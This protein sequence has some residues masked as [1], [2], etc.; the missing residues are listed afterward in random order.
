MTKTAPV[1]L[2]SLDARASSDIPFEFEYILPNGEG[3]GIFLSILGS[4]SKTVTEAVNKMMNERRRI[5][6]T[7]ELNARTGGR[8][9]AAII[10]VEDDIAFGQKMAAIRLVGWKGIAEPFDPDLALELCEMNQDIANQINERSN[11]L[12]NF[13]KGSSPA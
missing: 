1:S 7:A 11:D 6:E 13:M 5:A 10:P 2:K 3:S 4:Q 9:T 12:A 8:K